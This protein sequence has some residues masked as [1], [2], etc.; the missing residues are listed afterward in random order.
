MFFFPAR[1]LVDLAEDG[2]LSWPQKLTANHFLSG[3][4]SSVLIEKAVVKRQN[5]LPGTQWHNVSHVGTV[6]NITF[7]YRVVCEQNYYGDSCSM[8]CLP[9]DDSNG[10]YTCDSS[11]TRVCLPG[12]KGSFCTE[13]NSFV[14]LC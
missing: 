3:V 2:L 4:S 7:S 1:R 6:A 9:R 8:Y 5:L 10:H 11:G 12:W 13:G 14:L